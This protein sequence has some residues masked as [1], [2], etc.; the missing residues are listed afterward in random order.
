MR[1]VTE[2]LPFPMP[3]S[4]HAVY[5]SWNKVS[6]LHWRVAPEALAPYLP[7]GLELDLYEGTAYVGVVPFMMEAVYPRGTMPLPG[8]SNF[9]EFNIRT[10]VTQDGKPGVFFLTLEAQSRISCAY[11]P[12]A[13]GLPYT[14]CRGSVRVAQDTA[15]WTS[16]RATPGFELKG[17]CTSTGAP[18]RAQP[19]SLEAFLFERYCLYTM[20]QGRLCMA[21]TQHNPWEFCEAEATLQT[22]TLTASF[23][24]GIQDVLQPDLTHYSK[25]VKV[26]SWGLEPAGP[27]VLGHTRDVLLLDG[28]CGLC[29]RLAQFLD[30][31]LAAGAKLA[32]RPIESPEGQALISALPETLRQADSVYL[33]RKGRAYIRSAAAIRC[34]LYMTWPWRLWYPVAWLI[35]KPLRDLA[36]RLV[37]RFR[38]RFFRAPKVC[39]FRPDP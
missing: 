39:T 31:R 20:H 13:Y 38:Y 4:P 12:R 26:H 37:A 32:Y 21:Y 27:P 34:A 2:H 5:Q 33:F 15:S 35:P 11:A 3:Q 28:D 10:Y 23:N 22:N 25:G 8:I 16:Q 18:Q 24:L 19:G 30:P 17:A 1:M 14:Y 6:F 7:E 29:H 9:A 36:Y